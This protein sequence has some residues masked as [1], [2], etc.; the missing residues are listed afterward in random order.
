LAIEKQE[1]AALDRKIRAARGE[2]KAP[3]AGRCVLRPVPCG[4]GRAGGGAGDE[5]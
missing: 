3:P 2:E 4:E 5:V 1:K